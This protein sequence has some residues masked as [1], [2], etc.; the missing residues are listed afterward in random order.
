MKKSLRYLFATAILALAL[1]LLLG[2]GPKEG[3]R[4]VGN[5]SSLT[6]VF[7]RFYCDGAKQI[8]AADALYFKD[9]NDAINMGYLPCNSCKP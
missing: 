7:H 2:V 3:Y 9:R 4:F 8:K 6:K 1:F 5:R